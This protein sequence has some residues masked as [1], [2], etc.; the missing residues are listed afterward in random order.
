MRQAKRSAFFLIMLSILSSLGAEN[1]SVL[2]FS[3][4]AKAADYDWLCKGLADMLISDF[5]AAKELTVVEREDLEKV[6][7]EQELSLSGITSDKDA[8]GLGKIL[9]A[10]KLV[11]GSFIVLTDSIRIDAKAIDSATGAVAGAASVSGKPER[12]LDMEKELSA[13]LLSVLGVK[14]AGLQAQNASLAAVKSYYSGLM[15]YD[16]GDYAKAIELFKAAAVIDPSYL[17]PQKGIEASYTFLKDFKKMRQ[18]SEMSDLAEDIALLKARLAAE[19]FYSFADMVSNP[20]AFGYASAADASAAYQARPLVFYGNT[21]LQ[22]LVGLQDMY[23]EL[24]DLA[25]EY[26]GDKELMDSC[27]SEEWNLGTLAEAEYPEDPFLPEAL[28]R[29]LFSL[30]HFEKWE[31]LKDACERLMLRYPKFRMMWAIED[32][33]ERALER[34]KKN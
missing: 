11:Y 7:R 28:Y 23:R 27:Y 17:K 26:F 14:A 8:L 13:K 19:R 4:T 22:A 1:L 6:L 2:Y 15:L 29:V 32:F 9:N 20:I 12:V 10:Q 34:M 16:S 3:N 24:G 30:Q 18:Q 21:P 5:S 25:M 33:Y 31:G